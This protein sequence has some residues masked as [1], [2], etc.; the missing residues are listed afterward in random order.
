MVQWA[1][2][3]KALCRAKVARVKR[4]Y[5]RLTQCHLGGNCGTWAALR[6]LGPFG[7]RPSRKEISADSGEKN[8]VCER[9]TK[10]GKVRKSP[11]SPDQCAK[12]VRACVLD[13]FGLFLGDLRAARKYGL[14]H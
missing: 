9:A 8:S 5:R 2:T 10:R 3:V 13:F 11:K 12:S 14:S 1:K 6:S 4:K 7:G